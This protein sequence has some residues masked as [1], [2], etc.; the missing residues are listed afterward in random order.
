MSC[1]REPPRPA[2]A[3]INNAEFSWMMHQKY[4]K[5]V[6]PMRAYANNLSLSVTREKIKRIIIRGYLRKC[7]TNIA[8]IR[9]LFFLRPKS[10]SART[11]RKPKSL[12]YIIHEI[13]SKNS[14]SR[15]STSRAYTAVS[16]RYM[17]QRTTI[18]LQM[19]RLSIRHVC[20]SSM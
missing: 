4:T 3:W 15:A 11:L 16:K 12:I 14:S 10:P 20:G 17:K 6:S 1:T 19:R 18:Y 9:L 7:I 2:V 13:M 8:I 5:V